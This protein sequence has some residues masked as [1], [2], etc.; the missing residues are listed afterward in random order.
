M[1]GRIADKLIEKAYQRQVHTDLATLAKIL[2]E[3][4]KQDPG[5][6]TG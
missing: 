6:A 3:H 5:E 1:F 2:T 4:R